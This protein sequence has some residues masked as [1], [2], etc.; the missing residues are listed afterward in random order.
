ML[1]HRYSPELPEPV[2]TCSW[3]YS[4]MLDDGRH[5][6]VCSQCGSTQIVNG[7]DGVIERRVCRGT[8]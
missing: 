8:E 7:L 6:Y 2:M 5:E 3:T 1:H 4:R